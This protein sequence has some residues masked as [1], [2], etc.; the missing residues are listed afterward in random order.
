[1]LEKRNR[2][3]ILEDSGHVD[4]HIQTCSKC[5]MIGHNKRSCKTELQPVTCHVKCYMV[6]TTKLLIVKDSI[7]FIKGV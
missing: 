1:M 2:I 7:V 5:K 4:K 3:E 6:L